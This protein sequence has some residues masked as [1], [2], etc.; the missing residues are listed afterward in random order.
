MSLQRKLDHKIIT[1]QSL[2]TQ[3]SNFASV[4]A[5]EAHLSTITSLHTIPYTLVSWQQQLLLPPPFHEGE[6]GPH[7]SPYELKLSA[8]RQ[9]CYERILP[10]LMTKRKLAL[11]RKWEQAKLRDQQLY[12]RWLEDVHLAEQIM[13]GSHEAYQAAIEK[14]V[15]LQAFAQYISSVSYSV[16]SPLAIEVNV[17]IQPTV[18]VPNYLLSLTKTGKLS[19]KEMPKGKYFDYIQDFVCSCSLAIALQLQALLPVDQVYIHCNTTQLDASIGKLTEQTLLSVCYERNHLATIQL[20][21]I[22]PSNLL[23]HTKHQMKFMKLSGFKPVTKLAIPS[24]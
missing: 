16:I 15:P 18:V 22:D 3:F 17:H 11:Q 19:S 9:R 1:S 2:L 6:I 5:Y 8:F 12:N 23:Q 24:L 14:H 21:Y 7:A 4:Q 13:Q 10:I 20:A